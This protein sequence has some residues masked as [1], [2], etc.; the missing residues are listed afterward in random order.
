MNFQNLR[1]VN[2]EK[3][4]LNSVL[5]IRAELEISTLLMPELPNVHDPELVPPLILTT[6]LCNTDLNVILPSSYRFPKRALSYR[7]PTEIVYTSCVLYPSHMSIPPQLPPIFS[8]LIS[9]LSSNPLILFSPP[10]FRDHVSRLYKMTRKIGV[11]CDLFFSFPDCRREDKICRMTFS[12]ITTPPGCIAA[13]ISRKIC[14]C[15]EHLTVLAT[16]GQQ[17]PMEE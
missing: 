8:S 12:T 17:V 2:S 4:L 1:N 7:F 16:R 6:F 9:I 3:L 13:F 11:M 14:P 10:M 5:Q 15:S